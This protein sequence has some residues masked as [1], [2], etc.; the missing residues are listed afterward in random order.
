MCSDNTKSPNSTHRIL[1]NVEPEECRIALTHDFTLENF[2]IEKAHHQRVGNI[3]LG[4]ISSVAPS[5]D[6]VFVDFGSERQGFLPRKEIA[7]QYY[8]KPM[9]ESSDKYSLKEQF[10]E[11]QEIIIQVDKEE[12]GTKGAAITSFVT[13]AGS[14]LVLMPNNPRAGGI[15]RR[16]EG[17]ERENLKETLSQLTVPE[18]M[19]LIIRTAGLGKS[20]EELQ[21]DL[22]ILLRH[23]QAIQEACK[24]HTA[25]FLIYQESDVVI[26]TIRDHLRPDIDE[27]IIDNPEEY[28]KAKHHIEQIRPSFKDNIKLYDELVPIFNRYQ[29][30]NQVEMAFQ[31]KVPLPSGGTIVIEE[32]E[33]LV[34]IDVNSG[35]D[36]QGLD[37]EATAFNTNIEAVSVAAREIIKRDLSG[38]IVFDFIDMGQRSNQRKIE[39]TVQEV[40]AHDRARTQYGSITRFGT[41]QMSRQ[42]LRPSLREGTNVL[43]PRC[44][45][46]G[47]IRNVDSLALTILRRIRE[48]AMNHD[49][50]E[51][52]AE[53]PTTVA[54][55]LLN[56]KRH[57]MVDLE[58]QRGISIIITPNPHLETP[59]YEI[60]RLRYSDLKGERRQASYQTKI[61]PESLEAN[62]PL[63]PHVQYE[64]PAV[65]NVP[66]PEGKPIPPAKPG[67]LK[68]LWVNLFAT[69]PDTEKK[70]PPKQGSTRN[71][72]SKSPQGRGGRR[73]QQD[74]RNRG[75]QSRHGDNTQKSARHEDQE[76]KRQRRGRKDDQGNKTSRQSRRGEHEEAP[77]ENRRKTGGGQ[78][79]QRSDR[80]HSNEGNAR[81][82]GGQQRRQ[83]DQ[84]GQRRQNNQS[85]Q[86]DQRPPQKHNHQN[87]G[88]SQQSVQNRPEKKPM[89]LHH[90]TQD[91]VQKEPTGY[92][93]QLP[94]AANLPHTD[95]NYSTPLTMQELKSNAD[96]K[97]K[98]ARA[99][100][101]SRGTRG[102]TGRKG[103]GSSFSAK[104][105]L[106]SRRSSKEE[107][108]EV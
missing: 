101:T 106:P 80:R 24:D 11:G 37:L 36:T 100:R 89:N 61:T 34:A 76:E 97:Q 17:D 45:G 26:R 3:Y 96:R 32:T 19:G 65:Q 33:A 63:R 25:P 6:A 39:D 27:V 104:K 90:T 62:T 73:Q 53:V 81:R 13:L 69:A 79:R 23:W 57:T 82:Q 1:I 71:D 70:S 58:R 74:N 43:C 67:L 50:A 10:K 92:E 21:W 35:R 75:R 41:L 28:A 22:E 14:Y 44:H 88:R 85:A 98:T 64:K 4:V 91:A 38:I 5:L 15:S 46:E 59:L 68:K 54:S 40:F 48:Y 107:N 84:Q 47:S 77:Q 60:E 16:I 94:S 7:P 55:Y 105:S 29:I 108:Q 87:T 83:E 56:E 99:R 2:Y 51:V 52:R 103:S 20:V 8:L 78:Q 30:E 72:S 66:T 86:R 102:T 42:R 49:T 93:P 31:K 9:D 95:A 18:G 12:R